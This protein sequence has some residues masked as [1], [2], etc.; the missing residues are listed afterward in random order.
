[1][2]ELVSEFMPDDVLVCGESGGGKAKSGI[3]W[4]GFWIGGWQGGSL[5]DAVIQFVCSSWAK[6]N[7]FF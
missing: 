2:S 1:M 7:I 5:I 3:K 6:K 4:I